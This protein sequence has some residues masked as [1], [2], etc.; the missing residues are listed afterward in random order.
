MYIKNWDLFFEGIDFEGNFTPL[1]NIISKGWL[2]RTL[3]TDKIRLSVVSRGPKGICV[4][5]SK[6][7]SHDGNL[8]PKNGYFR[9]ILNKELLLQHG[10]RSYPIDEWK[11][12]S[13]RDLENKKAVGRDY[14][15]NRHRWANDSLKKSTT[16]LGKANFPALK[17]GKRPVFNNV[18]LRNPNDGGGP[19]LEVEYEE[20]ILKPIL[21]AGRF[22]YAINVDENTYQQNKKIIDNY[23]LRY[24]HIKV[25]T[26]IHRFKELKTDIEGII[27]PITNSITN[28]AS[29]NHYPYAKSTK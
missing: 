4:T 12:G 11:L 9:L 15:S 6:Y 28:G 1:Y 22:I 20:R 3:T 14:L 5:R 25:L 16:N 10:Y 7:F 19:G 26:G 17:A 2:D 8:D 13:L 21:K 24:P 23:I 18:G 27:N 29:L